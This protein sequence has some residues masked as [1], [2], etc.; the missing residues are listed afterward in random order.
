MVLLSQER[1]KN[2]GN[3]LMHICSSCG[4]VDLLDGGAGGS[5]SSRSSTTPG[6]AAGHAPWNPTCTLVQLGHDG[7]AQLLQL[8]LLM[9]KL[10]FFCRL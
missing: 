3:R 6:E 7:V 9:F 2:K 1:F 4:L 8:F 10:I 5:S